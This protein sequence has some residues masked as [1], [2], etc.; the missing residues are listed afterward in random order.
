MVMD[1]RDMVSMRDIV[2][3]MMFLS[4]LLGLMFEVPVL[5]SYLTKNGLMNYRWLSK[6][7]R[8]IIVGIFLISAFI[9]PPDPLSQIIMAIPLIVLFEISLQVVR[10]AERKTLPKI[11]W[12]N[13]IR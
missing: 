1:V 3:K 6:Y 4:I 9:T 10:F 5:L 13:I 2:F 8:H 11:I 12:D 7:R